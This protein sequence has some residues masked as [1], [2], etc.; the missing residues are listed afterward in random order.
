MSKKEGVTRS[1]LVK[2]EVGKVYQLWSN[3]ENFPNFMKNI[4]SVEKTGERTSHWVM[5]GPLGK[6]VQWDA[7]TTRLDENKRVAWN[8]IEGDIQTSGQVTFNSMP[9]GFTEVTVVLKYVPKAGLLGDIA[10]KLFADPEAQLEEDL[11][12]FKAFAEGMHDRIDA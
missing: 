5:K 12:N 4:K 3:F 11:R 7:E 1:I 9:D 8:S 2:A 10:E 6:E